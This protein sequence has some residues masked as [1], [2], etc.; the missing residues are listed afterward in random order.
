M[1]YAKIIKADIANGEGFR[2]SLYVSGCGRN[3]PGCFN[4][5]AQDPCYGKLFDD[6][7]KEI[8]YSELKNDWCC[9]LSLLG[10]E[11]MSKLSDNRKQI[12]EFAKEIKKKFPNK[13]IWMWS[14][15]SYEEIYNSNDMKEILNY[16]D[17]LIDSPFIQE[18]KDVTLLWKGS[19]NQR[20]IDVKKS[21]LEN[22]VIL[23]E[24]TK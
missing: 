5:A 23:D 12:I 10:G 7:A 16:I 22:I 9:G 13:S 1:N 17:V 15:Y 3:C 8:I 6:A 18:L 11:P 2:I 14:G 21:S 19:S 24:N 4:Q 20:V